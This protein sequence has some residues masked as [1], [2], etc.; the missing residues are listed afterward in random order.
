MS[1]VQDD[2]IRK[3]LAWV[4]RVRQGLVDALDD[5]MNPKIRVFPTVDPL[6][7]ILKVTLQRPLA[8]ATRQ[9]LREY[10]RGVASLSGCELPVINITDRWIQA[11]VLTETRHWERDDKGKFKGPKRFERRPR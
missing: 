6:R 10:M 2:I 9:P 5:V 8:N 11:E 3:R 4:E 7:F 1:N